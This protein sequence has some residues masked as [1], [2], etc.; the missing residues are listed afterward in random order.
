MNPDPLNIKGLQY[1]V[2]KEIESESSGT[3]AFS[4]FLGRAVKFLRGEEENPSRGRKI[5]ACF[6]AFFVGCTVIGLYPVYKGV[7]IWKKLDNQDRSFGSFDRVNLTNLFKEKVQDKKELQPLSLAPH[8]PE[9][10]DQI[11]PCNTQFKHTNPLEVLA[12]QEQIQDVN[13]HYDRVNLAELEKQGL[14]PTNKLSVDNVNYYCSKPF[15]MEKHHVVI[16]LVEFSGKVY[17]R[18]FYHSN[19]QGTWRTTPFALKEGGASKE[20]VLRFALAAGIKMDEQN[21]N[22]PSSREIDKQIVWLGKGPTESSTQLPTELICG[23]NRFPFQGAS[24]SLFKAGR[25]VETMKK[26]EDNPF[27]QVH[28]RESMRVEHGH[29]QGG[30]HFNIEPSKAIMPLN[31]ALHPNFSEIVLEVK[32]NIP[33]YGEVTAKVFYSTDKS[34][35]YLFYETKDGRAF[36]SNVEDRNAPINS[37]GVRNDYINLENMDSPLYE[38]PEQINPNFQPADK[39]MDQTG[40]YQSN[41][42][43]VR[44]L[45]IIKLYYANQGKPIPEQV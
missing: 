7:R 23:L 27:N 17:P 13:P 31:Q 2:S 45:P 18:I 42:N 33:I 37:F 3:S 14:L 4:H 36:L 8:D 28:L 10:C 41:W 12:L 11:D 24:K 34:L 6:L 21:I 38:Y 35:A 1:G 9:H 43:Y 16:A 40:T 22:F 32:Q 25:L 19:S 30:K 5:G 39:K 29:N 44:E 20:D 15:I 26:K